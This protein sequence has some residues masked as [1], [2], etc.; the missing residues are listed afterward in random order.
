MNFFNIS[1]QP[2]SSNSIQEEEEESPVE[3]LNRHKF[4]TSCSITY[5]ALSPL[6]NLNARDKVYIPIF[7]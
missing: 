4:L 1:L 7:S 2:R 3:F 5:L 6:V